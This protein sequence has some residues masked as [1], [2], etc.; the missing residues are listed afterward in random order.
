MSKWKL[1]E[2]EILEALTGSNPDFSN[3][4]DFDSIPEFSVSDSEPD[5]LDTMEIN[6]MSFEDVINTEDKAEAHSSTAD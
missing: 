4:D 6:G 2:K 1:S 3:Y 5:I